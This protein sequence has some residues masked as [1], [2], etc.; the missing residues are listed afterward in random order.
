MTASKIWFPKNEFKEGLTG[1]LELACFLEKGVKRIPNTL[2]T[3][4]R[5][6]W[7]VLFSHSVNIFV[8]AIMKG[9]I[10]SLHNVPLGVLLYNDTI[11]MVFINVLFILILY[12]LC[13]RLEKMDFFP[14]LICGMN[15]LQ[16]IPLITR[17][18][19]Y[20][21]V[22][23]GYHKMEEASQ[24]EL[25]LLAYSLLVNAFFIS[26]CL[27]IS[28]FGATYLIIMMFMIDQ[29]TFLMVLY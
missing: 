8:I 26:R 4:M 22:T 14:Q 7:I 2:E 5:S 11:R 15:W 29:T 6:F 24:L 17:T 12:W 10:E 27:K 25:T 18:P 20:W 3:A 28:I 9:E 1:A 21:M 19:L 16:V 13:K 23:S